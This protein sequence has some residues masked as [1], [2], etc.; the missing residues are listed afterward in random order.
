MPR[1]PAPQMPTP[2]QVRDAVNA[3]R[4]MFPDA[5]VVS[6]GPDGVRFD[7]PGDKV[8]P[9]DPVESWFAENGQGARE[10]R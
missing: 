9:S 10:G 8:T 2:T 4:E 6:I 1:A 7:Y 3:V 5:R